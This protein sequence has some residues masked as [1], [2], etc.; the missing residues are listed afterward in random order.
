MITFTSKPKLPS[1][2]PYLVIP[3]DDLRWTGLLLMPTVLFKCSGHCLQQ[4]VFPLA[5]NSLTV[6]FQNLWLLTISNHRY[7]VTY[8]TYRLKTK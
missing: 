5:A 4:T 7:A 1:L 6:T 3:Y 8:V 2:H